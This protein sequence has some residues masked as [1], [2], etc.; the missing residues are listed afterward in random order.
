M[1]ATQLAVVPG[2]RFKINIPLS[3][4]NRFNFEG[5]STVTVSNDFRLEFFED[6][7]F[8]PLTLR[9][10]YSPVGITLSFL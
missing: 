7:G 5:Y 1:N 10:I 9:E 4:R 3:L 6:S 8:P 2:D